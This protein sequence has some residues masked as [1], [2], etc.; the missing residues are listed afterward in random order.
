MDLPPAYTLD[1]KH[2]FTGPVRAIEFEGA[3]VR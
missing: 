2:T 3:G 1:Q